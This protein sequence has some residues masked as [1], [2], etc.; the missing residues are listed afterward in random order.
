MTNRYAYDPAKNLTSFSDGGGTVTY[1]YDELNLVTQ[2]TDPQGR[3]TTFAHNDD[4]SR[5]RVSFPYGVT[6]TMS[7]DR[8]ELTRIRSTKGT[9]V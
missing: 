9:S 7:Y 5:T 1:A 8:A 3:Q 4:N 6:E 2:L